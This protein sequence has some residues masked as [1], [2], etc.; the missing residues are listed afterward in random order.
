MSVKESIIST[1]ILLVDD[2]ETNVM[3]AKMML[4][5]LNCH[6]ECAS[7]G[8]E[9][10]HLYEDDTFGI[11]IMDIQMPVMDD[12]TTYINLKGL[13]AKL[14]PVVALTHFHRMT[15]YNNLIEIGFS[16]VYEK[17]ITIELC[18]TIISEW[19]SNTM[20]QTSI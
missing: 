20:E 11:I 4:T 9:A 5:T 15:K 13:N 19:K 2:S 16:A 10:I 1:N 3:L 7:D 12:V 17:P 18:K 8:E 6:I 14:P